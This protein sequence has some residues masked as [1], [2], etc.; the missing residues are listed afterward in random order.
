[1]GGDG[2]VLVAGHQC[3]AAAQAAAKIAG[4]KKVL[5]CD[6]PQYSGF[7]RG[8]SR[9]ADRDRSPRATR[10]SSRP[11]PVFGKNLM[12]RVAALLDVQQ[13]SDISAVDSPDTFVR[14]I[15]AGNVLATVQSTDT[16]KVVTVRGDRVRRGG[17]ERRPAPDR[18]ARAG[19][20][21]PACPSST[22]RKLHQVGRAPS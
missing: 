4:V 16:I 8:E 6:A 12:P 10:T 7:A 22:A 20:R 2:H 15:Y 11:P 17:G 1:M 5:L 3:G 13:I 19:R 18:E 14:P 21:M 9:G